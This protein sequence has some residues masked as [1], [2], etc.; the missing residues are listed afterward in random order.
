[1]EDLYKIKFYINDPET[2]AIKIIEQEWR[3][4]SE[5]LAKHFYEAGI[6]D[7]VT[8]WNPN[9]IY[10]MHFGKPL[11]KDS[12]MQKAPPNINDKNILF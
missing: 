4:Y 6:M 8:W 9:T 5:S 10:K 2:Q 12:L 11:K 1:M 3:G 7:G